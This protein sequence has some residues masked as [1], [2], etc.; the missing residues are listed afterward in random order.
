MKRVLDSSDLDRITRRIAHEIIE[1][2]RGPRGIVLVGIHTRGVPVAERLAAE[3]SKIEGVE[4][5]VGALDIGL[6]RDDLG[7]RPKVALARTSLP[8]SLE[9]TVVVL[10]DD[11]LF[12]GRTIR[13]ALDALADLGRPQAVQLAVLVDRGHRELPIRADFVGKNLPT[14]SSE[15]VT[16]R[17]H[18]VDGEEGVWLGEDT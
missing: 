4:V 14:S 8:S 18:E 9:G 12:T 10:V 6:Y 3:I 13:A 2:N 7:S 16:V 15:R 5:P 1:R 11:V 17:L